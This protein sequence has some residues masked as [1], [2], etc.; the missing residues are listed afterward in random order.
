ME[1]L[2]IDFCI[3]YRALNAVNKPDAYPIPNSDTLDS[4]GKS[5]I[6]PY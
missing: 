2:N 3:D 6:F 1:A 5:K 4:M